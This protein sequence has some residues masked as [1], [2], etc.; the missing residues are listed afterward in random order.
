MA[1]V[2]QSRIAAKQ[3]LSVL[4]V[5]ALIVP[6]AITEFA[7]ASQTHA[8]AGDFNGDGVTTPGL[9]IDGL[10]ILSGATDDGDTIR[11]RYGRP[12]DVPVVGD[13]TGNGVDTVGVVR[14]GR[15]W[16]LRFSNSAGDADRSFTYGGRLGRDRPVVG[17][18][19]GK[20]RDLPG[21]VRGTTWHLRN[22][23]AGGD[24]DISFSYGRVGRGDHPVTGDWNGSGVDTVGIVRDG[25]WHLKNTHTG[26]SADW[27]FSY[28][29]ST[30]V[31]VVGS[32]D[33][34]KRDTPGVVRGTSWL[35]KNSL[36]GGSAD[37]TLGLPE[38][39]GDAKVTALRRPETSPP[40]PAP[41]KPAPEPAPTPESGE[42]QGE[43]TRTSIGS[44]K[45]A[46]N[47]SHNSGVYT[48]SGGG[49]DIWSASDSFE[50][51]HQVLEG[52]GKVVVRVNSQTA[53][54][55]WAKAG[56]MI[57]SD[58]SP[59][60]QHV[61][62]FR[63][64]GHGAVLQYRPRPSASA[65]HVHGVPA[66]APAWLELERK[67]DTF[68][69]RSSNDGLKWTLIG[70]VSVA[71]GTVALVG[72]AVT[73]HDD[74]TASRAEFSDLQQLEPSDADTDTAT[75][76]VP[77]EPPQTD[78]APPPSDDADSLQSGSSPSAAFAA[79]LSEDELAVQRDRAANGPFR[80]AG[81]F[82]ANSPGHWNEMAATMRLNFS[83]ARW[84]GPPELNAN[85]S[86]KNMHQLSSGLENDPPL[87]TRRMAHDMMSAA[88]AAAITNDHAV[89][90]A[91]TKEIEYQATRP[92][93]DYS[94]RTLW[95][96]DFYNDVNPLFMHT[97]WIKDYV[98]AYDITKAMG[99]SSPIV[100]RWFLDL[101]EINEQIVHANLSRPFPNRKNN[102]YSARDSFVDSTLLS[103]TRTAD[104]KAIE[105]PRI[106]LFYN[107]RRSNQAG[108]YGLVGVVLND[109]YHKEEFK[110]YMR[111]WV[112]FGHRVTSSDGL[113]GDVNRGSDSFPQ[114][115]LSYGLH[116]MESLIPAMDGLARQG[117]TSLYEF[118]SSEGAATPRGGTNHYKTMEG[119]LDTYIRWIKGSYPAQYT[120]SGNPPPTSIAG[121]AYYRIQ[122]RNTANGR[123]MV[124][125]ASL[126]LPANYYNRTDWH[127]VI[128]R[129]GTPT[130]FTAN[131][132]GVGSIDGWRTD[133]RHRFLRSLDT[134]PYPTRG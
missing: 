75:D 45:P 112:M 129:R 42:V 73:S 23:L 63:T 108:F 26:G 20:G 16:Y 79:L 114:L 113:H 84:Q 30:D 52:D 56:L 94:N 90:A 43:L 102:S 119:V 28:G 124:N 48:L 110:R 36:S 32:W 50:F 55:E 121:S 80:T 60:A 13:W 97:V 17:D 57:R 14:R 76:T 9:F 29:R 88:Y 82:S 65:V 68:T 133:W 38:S 98:L 87:A 66:S 4:L 61:S 74:G 89:A 107:N 111:E 130:G 83:A 51:A 99:H 128:M 22:T 5:L 101:A 81:D 7:S 8:L 67:G 40:R 120:A 19:I 117:D 49:S 115:G 24:A 31:P 33:G 47:L 59:G 109:T 100:E 3:A 62:V 127:D 95:P 104:G 41:T 134:D 132:Q 53:A 72:L 126:L 12:D 1:T 34:R 15:Q 69:A 64:P 106:A 25:R 131:P 116:A 93:L 91:I 96:F 78:V 39:T 18:W 118:S 105:Y 6:M 86:V 58:L 85:G 35:L 21:I 44:P 92:R 125:D 2:N 27:T 77:T 37:M 10:F 46:G 123:E 70:S 11:F 54:H 71:M 103:S 122:S